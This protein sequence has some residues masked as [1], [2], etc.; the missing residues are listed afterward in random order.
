MDEFFDLLNNFACSV[1]IPSFAQFVVT[2]LK[3]TDFMT[4]L[5]N[6]AY[7]LTVFFFMMFFLTLSAILAATKFLDH[8]LNLLAERLAYLRGIAALEEREREQAD[9]EREAQADAGDAR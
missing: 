3:L 8:C 5:V 1:F 4:D 6:F 2:I 9:A 7:F